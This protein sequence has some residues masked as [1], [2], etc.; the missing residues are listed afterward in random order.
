[1]MHSFF[2]ALDFARS[3]SVSSDSATSDFDNPRGHGQG[4]TENERTGEC[5]KRE[6]VE[7]HTPASSRS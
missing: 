6:S 3:F 4:V 1:M 7:R 2:R 5:A